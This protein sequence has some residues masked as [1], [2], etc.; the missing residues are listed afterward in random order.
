MP[1]RRRNLNVVFFSSNFQLKNP[2]YVFIQLAQVSQAMVIFGVSAFAY[3]YLLEMY[4]LTFD[5][6][7]LLLGKVYIFLHFANKYKTPHSTKI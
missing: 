7:G 6:T 4:N 3:K 5:R 2:T 1:P